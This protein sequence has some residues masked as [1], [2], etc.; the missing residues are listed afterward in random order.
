MTVQDC[1]DGLHV[2]YPQVENWHYTESVRV[3]KRKRWIW[4]T[5]AVIV[6]VTGGVLALTSRPVPYE[7]LAGAKL[8]DVRSSR[9]LMTF[10]RS[11]PPR[12]RYVPEPFVQYEYEI[13]APEEEVYERAEHE[14]VDS[15][16]WKRELGFL[17]GPL[18]GLL[19]GPNGECVQVITNLRHKEPNTTLVVVSKPIG[20]LDWIRLRL[21]RSGRREQQ[22]RTP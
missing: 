13:N 2:A 4:I 14:L 12:S 18:S 3:K 15:L 7:F 20:P 8:N 17:N 1:F 10:H 19:E 6:V 22:S 16:G 21:Y 5:A 11:M 9:Q